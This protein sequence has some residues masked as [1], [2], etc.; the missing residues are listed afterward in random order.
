MELLDAATQAALDYYWAGQ[1]KASQY[2]I[3][4]GC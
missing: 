3:F 2:A 1:V 4:H